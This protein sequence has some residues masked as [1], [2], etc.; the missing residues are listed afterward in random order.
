MPASQPVPASSRVTCLDGLRG[1]AACTVV[2]FHF[3]YAFTP[4]P[5]ADR[6]RTGFSLFDTPLAVLWNGNFAVAVFFVLSGFVLAASSPKN[7]REAPLMIGLRYFRLGLPALASSILAW[8][9]LTGFPEAASEAQAISGSRWFRWTYQPPIPPLS[10]AIWEGG[11]GVFVNGTTRFNNPL[12]TMQA[13]FFGSV[14]I[15]GSYA[16]LKGRARPYA[17]AAGILAF[18]AVGLFYLAAFCGGALIYELRHRLGERPVLG[19]LVGLA[20]L[21][22]GASFA[23]RAAGPDLASQLIARLGTDGPRQAGAVLLVLAILMTPALRRLFESP[24]LQK[25]GELS[26]PIYLVHVPLIVA[27]ASAVF[28]ALSPMSPLALALLF[29]ATSAATLALGCVFLVAVERPVLATLKQIRT[30]ARA[31]LAAP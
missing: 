25:L 11:V 15:Y 13:E 1:F 2:A 5:F 20:G 4:G 29:V 17:M 28:A 21:V 10:Q 22:L 27:P 9:W 19:A 8:A 14:L 24:P 16:L 26:F 23:G 30:R 12:W 18:G 7:L 31:R 3:F 6:A